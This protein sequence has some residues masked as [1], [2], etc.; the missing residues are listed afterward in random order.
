MQRG[1]KVLCNKMGLW[2]MLSLFL[3]VQCSQ[4]VSN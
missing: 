4:V 2:V 1:A 3:L